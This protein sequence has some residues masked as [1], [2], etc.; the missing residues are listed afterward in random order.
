MG[1]LTG[2]HLEAGLIHSWNLDGNSTDVFTTGNGTDTAVTYTTPKLGTA[3]AAFNG[4]TSKITSAANG[5]LGASPWSVS[6]WVYLD[7]TTLTWPAPFMWGTSPDLV[8]FQSNAAGTSMGLY[9]GTV[10]ITRTH[11]PNAWHHFVGTYDG[12][13]MSLYADGGTPATAVTVCHVAAGSIVVGTRGTQWWGGKIDD[14][15]MWDRALTAGEV[16]S[17]YNS[18]TGIETMTGSLL[19]GLLHQWHLNG[20]S[21]DSV[22]GSGNG[23]DTAITYGGKL[24]QCAMFNGTTSKIQTAIDGPLGASP[25]SI[26]CW[27]NPTGIQGKALVGYGTA[28][29]A[30]QVLDITVATDSQIFANIWGANPKPTNTYTVGAWN[31]AVVTYDGTTLKIYLNNGTPASA[32]VTLT[33]VSNPFRFAWT[34]YT[35]WAFFNGLIDDV[36]MW[37]R[38]LSAAEVTNLYNG[39]AGK[40]Y[41]FN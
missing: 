2:S 39:G 4:V 18:G 35:P 32:T 14:T 30:N 34:T 5:P 24:G 41:P 17:L 22:D 23:T 12:T 31:H 19:T 28:G 1:L 21:V 36:H 6:M 26:S 20:T 38:A 25:R 16:A 3:C 7:R 9:N 29:V 33:T 8:V 37:N 15:C 10:E 13:T 40:Y 11:T 27:F